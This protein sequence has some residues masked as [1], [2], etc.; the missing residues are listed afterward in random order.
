M[1][2]NK[3]YTILKNI[4]VQEKDIE[5]EL[6]NI[7]LDKIYPVGSI[8]IS[9]D[10]TSPATLFGGT[11]EQIKD[12]FL[13]SAGDTYT[14]GDTGGE[15]THILLESEMPKHNHNWRYVNSSSSSGNGG[16][17]FSSTGVTAWAYEGTVEDSHYQYIEFRGGN[18]SHNNMPPYLAVY[19]WKRV[20]PT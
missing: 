5:K 6:E 13:L 4:I 8:Y 2:K 10:P 12:T 16:L 11:W 18:Q 7:L 15:A 14:A 19:V 1:F 9:V 3:L 20:Q 17:S